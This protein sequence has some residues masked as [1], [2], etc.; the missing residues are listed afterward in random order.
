MDWLIEFFKGFWKLI[1]KFFWWLIDSVFAPF[2][3]ALDGFFTVITS[4]FYL[5]FDGF[6]TAVAAVFKTFDLSS[7]LFSSVGSSLD[8]P[9][10]AIWLV[11]QLGLPQC[12]TMVVVAF[13]IRMLL[14]LL[15]AAVTRI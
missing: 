8:L 4:I 9:P 10:A 7:M 12:V 3:W 2:R 1:K 14:N 15:P 6:L 13:G 5:I 11:T